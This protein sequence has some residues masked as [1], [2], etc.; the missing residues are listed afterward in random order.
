VR[1][2]FLMARAH[3]HEVRIRRDGKRQFAKME[4]FVVQNLS[5][6]GLK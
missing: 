5:F 1:Q 4:I 3:E 2:A 6:L